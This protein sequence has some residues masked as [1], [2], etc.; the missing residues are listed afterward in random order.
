MSVRGGHGQSCWGTKGM[1]NPCAQQS[2]PLS[3]LAAVRLIAPGRAPAPPAGGAAGGTA[4]PPPPAPL[5]PGPAPSPAPSR[6]A[7][8]APRRAKG[9]CGEAPRA[10][11]LRLSRWK[12][13]EGPWTSPR[14][15]GLR[16]RGLRGGLRGKGALPGPAW[17]GRARPRSERGD[18]RLCWLRGLSFLR[19]IQSESTRGSVQGALMRFADSQQLRCCGR[20]DM[21]LFLLPLYAVSF[22]KI[23]RLWLQPEPSQGK[24]QKLNLVHLA[25]QQSPCSCGQRLLKRPGH[26]NPE[27]TVGVPVTLECFIWL[28]ITRKKA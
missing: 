25:C 1:A 11:E 4:P 16:G 13:Q 26:H 8:A 19:V 24:K 2:L 15:E 21:T 23:S 18:K 6:S 14:Q 20:V 28:Q 5:H 3:Y 7:R 22:S 12:M 27:T 9:E 10:W 17:P